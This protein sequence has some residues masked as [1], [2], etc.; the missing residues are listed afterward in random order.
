MSLTPLTKDNI[1]D[2]R[3]IIRRDSSVRYS[4]LWVRDRRGQPFYAQHK[5]A[6]YGAN[7]TDAKG[8]HLFEYSSSYLVAEFFKP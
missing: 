2:A 4:E 1:R 6:D 7:S 5:Y 3:V 8:G